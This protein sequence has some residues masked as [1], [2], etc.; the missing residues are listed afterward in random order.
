MAIE[1]ITFLDEVGI[2]QLSEALLSKVNNR[3]SE[4]I[5]Q[6]LSDASDEHHVV[7]AILLNQLLKTRDEKIS[8]NKTTIDANTE[9]INNVKISVTEVTTKNN[10]NISDMEKVTED[11]KSLNTKVDVHQLSES[12]D[13]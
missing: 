8:A 11:V 7:S 10:T 1:N 6:E 2:E 5:I 13:G 4:R 3:V 9:A 12:D